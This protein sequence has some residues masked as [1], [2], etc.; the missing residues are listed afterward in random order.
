MKLPATVDCLDVKKNTSQVLRKTL[1]DQRCWTLFEDS[2]HIRLTWPMFDIILFFTSWRDGFLPSRG[3]FTWRFYILIS[4]EKLP[5]YYEKD[6][7]TRKLAF[8]FMLAAILDLHGCSL[9]SSYFQPVK[10]MEFYYREIKFQATVDCLDLR[11]KL[12]MY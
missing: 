5:I 7:Y 10:E 6:Y 3:S 4:K 1:I 9:K 12:A 11:Q 2:G 8:P